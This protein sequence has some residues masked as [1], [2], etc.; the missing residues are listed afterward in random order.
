MT[1]LSDVE[2]VETAKKRL[3]ANLI[4]PGLREAVTCYFDPALPFAGQTFDHLGSNP[5]DAIVAD[6]LLAVT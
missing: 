6:D 1:D 4:T 5:S 2:V 3:V